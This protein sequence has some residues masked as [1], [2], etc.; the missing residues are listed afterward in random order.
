[1]IRV[2]LTATVLLTAFVSSPQA[3]EYIGLCEASTGV[4]LDEKHFVVAS[5]E[6]NVLQLYERG[7][8][9][10]I[11]KGFDLTGA[12][13]DKSDLEA[14]AR[15]GDRVY[16]MSSHS[17]NSDGE[18]KPKRKVFFATKIEQKDGLP[19]LTIVGKVVKNLRDPL[20][21]FA[22][23]DKAKLNIEGMGKSVV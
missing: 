3:A 2:L 23:I 9:E 5:D 6:T 22:S 7:K 8:P 17:F 13:F 19:T 10:P 20:V 15:I 18:D 11:S 4:F 16:W 12:T 21:A 1:M 14:S